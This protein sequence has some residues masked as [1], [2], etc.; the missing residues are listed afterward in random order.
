MSLYDWISNYKRA[1]L[2]AKAK[3][4]AQTGPLVDEA[5]ED[6]VDHD[7]VDEVQDA[8]HGDDPIVTDDDGDA[9]E[10]GPSMETGTAKG[11]LRFTAQHP[12]FATHG[13]KLVLQ[14]PVLGTA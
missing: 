4:S 10:L 12:L 2:P 14:G 8:S 11:I 3:T 7:E 13:L 9:S 5:V 1:K 6:D